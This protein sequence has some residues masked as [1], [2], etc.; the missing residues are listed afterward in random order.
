MA[1]RILSENGMFA[2]TYR[3]DR[4]EPFNS[5]IL[6]AWSAG[7]YAW[8]FTEM[9]LGVD[10]DLVNGKIRIEPRIPSELERSISAPIRVVRPIHTRSG[11]SL[12]TATVDPANQ[13]ITAS[14]KGKQRPEILSSAYSITYVNN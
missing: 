5:C 4:P 9:M 13:K 2:E 7:M 10:I 6:Q 12:L 14:F 8:A 11:Q 1:E 3:G